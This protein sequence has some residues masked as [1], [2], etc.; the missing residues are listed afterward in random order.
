MERKRLR[1]LGL[2]KKVGPDR[3]RRAE[4][5]LEKVNEGGAGEV[6]KMAEAARRGVGG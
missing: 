1:G 4:G 6:K 5:L 2:A 3:L